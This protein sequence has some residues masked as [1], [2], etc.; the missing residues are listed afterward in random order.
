MPKIIKCQILHTNLAATGADDLVAFLREETERGKGGKYICNASVSDVMAAEKDKELSEYLNG[1]AMAFPV[2]SQLIAEMHVQGYPVAKKIK[3]D[4]LINKILRHAV[5]DKKSVCFICSGKN[6]YEDLVD[7]LIDKYPGLDY[8][9]KVFDGLKAEDVDRDYIFAMSESESARK[10]IRDNAGRLRGITIALSYGLK[11]RKEKFSSDA[12]K[13]I[14]PGYIG[15][16]IRFIIATGGKVALTTLSWA[17]AL[18]VILAIFILSSQTGEVSNQT[19]IKLASDVY[20]IRFFG[21]D[22]SAQQYALLM[23]SLN[24]IVRTLGHMGEYALLAFCVGLAIT[25]NGFSGKIRVVYMLFICSLV[26]LAD[27]IFQFFIPDRYCDIFD[28]IT[29]CASVLFVSMGFYIL[30]KVFRKKNKNHLYHGKRRKF[31]NIF[32][33]DISFDEAID[34]VDEY[35]SATDGRKRYATTPN[36][37]HIVK[38]EK[39]ATFRLVYENADLIVTDGTPLMWIAESVG[40]PITEKIPGA[41]MLPR[42]CELAAK[43]GYSV[44]LLGAG[45]GVAKKAAEKLTAKNPGLNIAGTYSPP[46]GFENDEDEL[47][48]VF[49]QINSCSP[50]IL[51]VG[52]GAPKQE[53]F[54]YK[55]RN[56]MNFKIA[57]PFGAAIDFEAGNVKRAPKWMRK[58]GL[59]WFYR[60]LKEPGRLF[61]RYFVDDIKIFWLAWKYRY[62]IIRVVG[63]KTGF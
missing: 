24:E 20:R 38:L 54:I 32:I 10:W 58:N 15:M 46:M 7:K 6:D 3:T 26:S 9:L 23:E 39:D 17:P 12:S 45:D 13:R 53:K 14:K 59:E 2:S 52:L 27:E 35:C 56:R 8:E 33:D 21:F 37:D 44:F 51:V 62:E 61:K 55:Y 47:S 16:N 4:D 40:C 34:K 28:I 63:E 60:F 42:V 48:K 41:D 11:G 57:L 25:A 31:L 1:A 29:D 50:D 43:K 19:S 5:D 30:Q 36:A 49:D 18:A 22:I